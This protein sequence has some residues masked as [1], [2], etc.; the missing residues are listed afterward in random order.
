VTKSLT[1]TETNHIIYVTGGGFIYDGCVNWA[2]IFRELEVGVMFMDGRVGIRK[3]A[4]E[5]H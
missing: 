4:A 2:F 1:Y 5:K 3:E